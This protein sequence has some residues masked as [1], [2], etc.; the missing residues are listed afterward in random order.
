[1]LV[2]S[3]T[4]TIPAKTAKFPRC[5]AQPCAWVP[6]SFGLGSAVAVAIFQ[7]QIGNKI[8]GQ[9]Q[10]QKPPA[11]PGRITA[12]TLCRQIYALFNRRSQGC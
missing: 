3:K 11:K 5:R 8:P 1:M 12:L 9:N 4:G 2:P 6:E 10:N 7:D